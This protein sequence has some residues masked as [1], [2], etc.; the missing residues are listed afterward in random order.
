MQ[1]NISLT[2]PRDPLPMCFPEP[3]VT[4]K[5]EGQ[6]GMSRLPL[7]WLAVNC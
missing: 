3:Q 2:L 7:I 5:K 6:T 1:F 4:H